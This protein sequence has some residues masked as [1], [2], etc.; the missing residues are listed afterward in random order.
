MQPAAAGGGW[1]GPCLEAPRRRYYPAVSKADPHK[2]ILG[3]DLGGT[4]CAAVVAE[5][6]GTV[7]AR[8]DWPSRAER[9]PGAMLEDFLARAHGFLDAHRGIEVLGVAVGGPMNPN[10]AEV[11][12]PPHLPGWDRVPLGKILR[13]RL[14]LEVIVEHDAAACLLA[15]WLWGAARRCSVAIYLTMGTGCGAGIMADRRI[16]RGP[17]GQSPEVGHIRLSDYGP[18]L[19]GKVGSVE[20]FCSGQGIGLLAGHMFPREFIAPITARELSRLEGEGNQAARAVL[21]ESARRTGQLCALLADI[22][23]P[24]VIILGSLARYLDEWWTEAIRAAFGREALPTNAQDTRIV[25][26]ELGEF[27]GDLSSIAPC[28]FRRQSR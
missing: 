23:S 27:L 17:A 16:L 9:G 11:L 12:S 5:G 26:A 20:S 10:T 8:A 15:E 13:E 2:P 24:E 22:F 7:L 21:A 6:G 3:W 4:M 1:W 19:F 18:E 14:G 25:P 28:V